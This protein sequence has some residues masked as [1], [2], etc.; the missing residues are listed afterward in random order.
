MRIVDTHQHLWDLDRLSVP[1]LA[2]EDSVL[3]RS[4]VTS[5]YLTA[6]AGLDL[7]ASIYMEVDAEPSQH[8]LEVAYIT[9]VCERQDTPTVAAVVAARPDDPGFRDYLEGL[10]N[11]PYVK[12]VRRILHVDETP[13]G[14]CL[15][16]AFI[17]G[18]RLLGERGL[19]FDICIRPGE[20]NDAARLIELCPETRF[21]L[22]HSGNP[23][24][25]WQDFDA[26]RAAL[27]KVA[28]HDNVVCKVSGFIKTAAKGAWTAEN[29]APIVD[30]VF[31]AFGPRRVLFASDW[32]VCTL[33]VTLREWVEA[34][35]TIVATRPLE[36]QECLFHQNAE[37]FYGLGPLG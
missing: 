31:D 23:D 17:A 29:L 22:D 27:G 15:S 13:A 5:D 16:E 20:L 3:Q 32:P 9:E 10:R 36:E 37:R 19:C 34:L 24:V 6:T 1:W 21:V 11:N 8:E 7:A 28:T 2:A 14:H 30:H 25:G 12:G 26:W 33:T 18:V 4:H 35:Q